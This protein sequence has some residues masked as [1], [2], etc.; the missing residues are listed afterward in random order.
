MEEFGGVAIFYATG[1]RAKRWICMKQIKHRHRILFARQ[2]RK[3]QT[4]A[5]Q[6]LWSFLRKR[7]H[8]GM[9]FRRQVPLGRYIVDFA[10]FA[11][12]LVIEADGPYHNTVRMRVRD[13]KRDDWLRSRGFTVLRFTNE[14]ILTRTR[15]VLA[16]IGPRASPE[17]REQRLTR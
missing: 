8:K 14:Q 3:R 17:Q 10:C 2:L 7:Q 5:E 15:E 12:R 6:F 11:S 4:E 16:A 1:V 13:R 9:K